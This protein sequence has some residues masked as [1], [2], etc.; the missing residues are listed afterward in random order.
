MACRGSGVQIPSAP[1]TKMNI[2]FIKEIISQTKDL[3]FSQFFVAFVSL[4]QVSLVVKILGVEKYGIVTLMVTLP[5]LIFRA[6]HG[7][8]SDV[9]LLSIK[10]GSALVYSYFFDLII[11]ILS[12]SICIIMLSL[13]LKSYFGINNLDTYI[14][15]FIASRIFQTFS[16]SSKAWLIKEGNLRKFSILDSLSVGVRFI[17][18]VTLISILSLIHI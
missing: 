15:I 13:P 6:F 17:A 18:I 7:K 12:F 9:T 16:E 1:L 14:I 2:S 11:G 10:R 3:A 5:S 8:N 4:L